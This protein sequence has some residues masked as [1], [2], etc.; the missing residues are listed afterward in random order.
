MTPPGIDVRSREIL[1]ETNFG[2]K[3]N[4]SLSILPDSG[5]NSGA[6]RATVSDNFTNHTIRDIM[7]M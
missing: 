2:K 3:Y 1:S 5:K 7:W 4:L 6:S